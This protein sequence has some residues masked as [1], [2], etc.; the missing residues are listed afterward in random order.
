VSQR[1]LRYLDARDEL[2]RAAVQG[3]GPPLDRAE[4]PLT[5]QQPVREFRTFR[6]YE[7][8]PERGRLEHRREL[9]G[10][11]WQPE[12]PDLDLHHRGFYITWVAAAE[13]RA[14]CRLLLRCRLHLNLG[15]VRLAVALALA[16]PHVFHDPAVA[17][18]Y[19]QQSTALGSLEHDANVRDAGGIVNEGLPGWGSH[20]PWFYTFEREWAA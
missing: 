6:E 4:L 11:V 18:W 13:G 8:R 7:R 20:E 1:L 9:L 16:K 2:M 17:L 15:R 14:T 3:A 19:D 5:V 10:A 12:E